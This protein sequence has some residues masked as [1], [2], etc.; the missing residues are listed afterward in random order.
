V[1]RNEVH[2]AAHAD[3]FLNRLWDKGIEITLL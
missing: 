1:L 2:V 3:V